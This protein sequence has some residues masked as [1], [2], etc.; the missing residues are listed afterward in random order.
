MP[1]LKSFIPL[2]QYLELQIALVWLE[3]NLYPSQKS[4]DVEE[5]PLLIFSD[6]G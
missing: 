2:F 6:K 1:Y 5:I 4:R 3:D